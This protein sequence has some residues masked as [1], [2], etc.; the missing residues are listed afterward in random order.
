MSTNQA[1]KNTT[2]KTQHQQSQQPNSGNNT[3]TAV[4]FSAD[5]QEQMHNRVLFLF[6]SFVG[7]V[8]QVSVK[9][10][11]TYEGVFHTANI[12]KDFGIV[13]RMVRKLNFNNGL[14]ENKNDVIDAPVPVLIIHGKDIVNI[15]AANMTL[16]SD[17]TATPQHLPDGFVVD[18]EISGFKEMKERELKPWMAPEDDVPRNLSLEHQGG[19]TSWDQF[20][21]NER[22]FKVKT[23]YQEEIYTTKLDK[24][25]AFYRQKASAAQKI[26]DEIEKKVSNNIHML[27]ERGHIV[28]SDD[29]DEE[30]LYSSVLR[31]TPGSALQGGKYVPPHIRNSNA[32]K[33]GK[34]NDKQRDQ[35]T[36]TPDSQQ[37]SK[38]QFAKNKP[39]QD[40]PQSKD[41]A[42]DEINLERPVLANRHKS[43]IEPSRSRDRSISVSTV[44]ELSSNPTPSDIK[45]IFEGET[46]ELKRRSSFTIGQLQSSQNASEVARIRKLIIDQSQ[47]PSSPKLGHQSP[48]NSPLIS[49]P[50]K[51]EALVLEPAAPKVT[52]EIRRQFF[53]YN[54]LNKA[55][56]AKNRNEEIEKL[57]KFSERITSKL[58]TEQPR[59]RSS[60]FSSLPSPLSATGLGG[61]TS[62]SSTQESA[63]AKSEATTAQDNATA[64]T[65]TTAATST[66]KDKDNKNTTATVNSTETVKQ[67]KETP[68][69]Q[70][71]TTTTTTTQDSAVKKEE[72]TTETSGD[73]NTSNP[74]TEDSNKEPA[75]TST[76][77]SLASKLSLKSKLNP[78]AKPFKLNVS[79]KPFVPSGSSISTS[80][81]TTAL[82]SNPNVM[83]TQTGGWK[84]PSYPPPNMDPNYHG[85]TGYPSN[86]GMEPYG[87]IPMYSHGPQI[88]TGPPPPTHTHGPHTGGPHMNTHPH[89]AH[90]HA[91]PV[92]MLPHHPHPHHLH[93][94]H[95]PRV[96][97]YPAV[98]GQPP[99]I[100][101]PPGTTTPNSGNTPGGSMTP[102]TPGDIT[103]GENNSGT[104]SPPVTSPVN[105]PIKIGQQ[106]PQQGMYGVMPRTVL[107]PPHF[108][109]PHYAPPQYSI[110]F[111]P[112][113]KPARFGR[114]QGGPPHSPGNMQQSPPLGPMGEGSPQQHKQV[115]HGNPNSNPN[116][117]SPSNTRST[118]GNNTEPQTQ[119][120]GQK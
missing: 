2:S 14:D 86:E 12:N 62:T 106:N 27:E 25:S 43:M 108:I 49:D 13:L 103:P 44:S 53:E 91:I 81:S 52:D 26:A 39:T 117:N 111:P 24:S 97:L 110:G 107:M 4:E 90:P 5:F 42:N 92:H 10:G 28:S 71:N 112:Q 85:W 40:L 76:G 119:V 66:T 55:D 46:T 79:A 8:V 67:E 77:G 16:S 57:K 80:T 20:A 23:T 50:G 37:Q 78:N 96:A 60:S 38:S 83:G 88:L 115:Y 32:S 109:Q 61:F 6:M 15:I 94:P 102:H 31:P 98:Y 72:K 73:K 17:D 1:K 19:S 89:H 75:S 59:S 45:K 34:N 29:L 68:K 7:Q 56:S 120:K 113:F 36:D 9:S 118:G 35:H 58:G 99:I 116:L 74:V 87:S 63:P 104:S 33:Q 54:L 69:P 41:N 101:G 82:K 70:D 95:H 105:A 22:L 93:G 47:G 18:T 114:T 48:L 21:V 100:S 84:N 64:T 11:V 30:D 3:P 65:A 51:I